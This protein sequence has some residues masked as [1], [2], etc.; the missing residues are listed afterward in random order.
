MG[1]T[2]GQK[3]R[4]LGVSVRGI[5]DGVCTADGIADVFASN[6]QHLYTSVAH[7]VNDM[8]CTISSIDDSLSGHR[9]QS[10]VTCEEVFVAINKLKAAKNG[11]IGLSSD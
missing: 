1:V 7:D 3:Q 6:Y 11:D 10:T 5:V 4:K 9:M 2:S 8:N